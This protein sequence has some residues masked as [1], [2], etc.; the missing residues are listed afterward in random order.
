VPM[1]NAKLT[2]R[3]VA[4]RL[5][6]NPDKVVGWIRAGELPAI[7]VARRA[8]GRARYR[9]DAADLAVFEA[10]RR[11]RP[12]PNVTGRRRKRTSSDSNVI[13]FF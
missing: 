1:K 5:N 12:Q 10:G 3:Q 9:V 2:P 8:G 6:V 13:E 4:E 11:V 7:N